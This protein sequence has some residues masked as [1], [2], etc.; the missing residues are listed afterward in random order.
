MNKCFG[1]MGGFIL[2]CGIVQYLDI[3]DPNMG[4]AIIFGM[5]ILGGTL[6]R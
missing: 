1:F 3:I 2:S 6:S 4:L 5:T